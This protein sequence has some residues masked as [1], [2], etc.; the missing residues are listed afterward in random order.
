[1]RA[2][3]TLRTGAAPDGAVSLEEIRLLIAARLY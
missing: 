3:E 1:M 2:E